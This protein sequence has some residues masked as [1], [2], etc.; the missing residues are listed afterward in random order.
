M[1]EGHGDGLKNEARPG[2]GFERIREHDW[3]NRHARQKSDH[4]I[5]KSNSDGG[6]R[7]RCAFG[8]VGA[9]DHD[10]AHAQAQTKE[11]LPHSSEHAGARKVTE[12]WRE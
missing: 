5:G 10:G 9:V 2:S 4:G 1:S 6:T 8:H 7:D 3:K 11:R 12:V